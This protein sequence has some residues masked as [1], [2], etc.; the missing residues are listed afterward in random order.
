MTGGATASFSG[1]GFVPRSVVDV[2]IF[3]K[4]TLL[5]TAIVRADGTY[6]VTV[7]ISWSLAPGNHTIQ[8]QGFVT[9]TTRTGFSVGVIVKAGTKKSVTLSNFASGSSKLTV[10]MQRT[11]AK[12]AAS[13]VRDGAASVTITGFNDNV[14]TKVASLIIGHRRAVAVMTFLRIQLKSRHYNKAMRI[15]VVTLG[16]NKPVTSNGNASGR[17]ANRRVVV[18][19]SLV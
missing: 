12:L 6:S 19:V 3:S 17:A 10:S 11:L 15:H 7:P 18:Q 4:G 1:S 14:G 9:A 5:G 2:Y 8:L 16:A 13:I